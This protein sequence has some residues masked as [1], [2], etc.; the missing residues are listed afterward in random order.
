LERYDNIELWVINNWADGRDAHSL[1][2][3]DL[4]LTPGIVEK[5][6]VYWNELSLEEI[7]KFHANL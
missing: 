7:T 1:A 4:R 5:F 6:R 2:I 3:T